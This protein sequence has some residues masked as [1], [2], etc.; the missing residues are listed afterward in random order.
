MTSPIEWNS[1]FDKLIGPYQLTETE[2]G[3]ELTLTLED[4]HMNPL[5]IT[6]GG[7]LLTLIDDVMGAAAMKAVALRPAVTI[8]LSTQF[9]GASKVGETL[10]AQG[11]VSKITK[12]L[13]FVTGKINVDDKLILTASGIWKIIQPR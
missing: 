11:V 13:V 1:G 9:L 4:K 3:V 7:L 8:E 2:S 6:H 10:K 5:G 12:H